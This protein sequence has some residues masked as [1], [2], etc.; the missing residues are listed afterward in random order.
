MRWHHRVALAG[1][2]AW[3]LALVFVRW[4]VE[5]EVL[6]T[7]PVVAK[8]EHCQ[9]TRPPSPVETVTMLVPGDVVTVRNF[10]PSDDGTCL[11]IE[12]RDGTR[13]MVPWHGSYL[14]ELGYAASFGL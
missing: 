6:R 7:L 4:G 3:A 14:R 12:L 8:A 1:V 9:L 13:G 5:F 10:D 2:V 11:H